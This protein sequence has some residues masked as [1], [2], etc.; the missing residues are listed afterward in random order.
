MSKESISFGCTGSK[1]PPKTT[2]DPV[3]KVPPSGSENQTATNR[4]EVK[5]PPTPSGFTD[6]FIIENSRIAMDKASLKSNLEFIMKVGIKAAGI[7]RALQKKLANS[8]P[9]PR[10]ELE[11]LKEKIV[12]LEKLK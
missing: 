8:P 12:A 4:S 6:E 11:Q 7:S 2:V 10:A 1:E 5:A 9:I 3:S